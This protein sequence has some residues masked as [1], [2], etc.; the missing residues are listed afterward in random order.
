MAKN[1]KSLVRKALNREMN[2]DE[3]HAY[4]AKKVL[5]NLE[6]ERGV[7]SKKL[8]REC[9]DYA[10]DILGDK[11]YA[12]W[13]YVYSAVAGEF[14]LG[15]IPDNFYGAVVVPKL[16]GHYG[17]CSGL[18]PLNGVFFQAKEF[19][20][21]GSFINGL[22]LDTAY[23]V[24][25]PE[26]FKKLLF[27][28]C[29]R[30]VFKV[31]NSLKGIGIHFFDKNNFTGEQFER[32]G[33]GVFQR[34]VQQHEAFD[35]YTP[36]SVATI[37]ITTV[38]DNNGAASVRACYLRLG[39]ELD[40]HVQSATAVKIPI[41]LATGLLSDTGYE[42]SWTTIHSHPT[43][44]KGFAN[45]EIPNFKKCL[46]V[47]TSLHLKVPYVRCIGWDLIVDT[48]GEVIV[49]EWNG[50]HNGIKFT[51]ATQGPSFADLGWEKLR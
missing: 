28:D 7:L 40:T 8:I 45:I 18:K 42:P 33:N 4:E 24:H 12:H 11:K 10:A 9:D 2:F 46:D 1:V 26:N 48:Q 23:K 50:D 13:L 35:E 43:S 51:E 29:E 37:R 38:T 30:I 49:L 21:L 22:F 6:H 25:S 27:A 5:K 3:A 15:W 39:T 16:K 32:L 17:N 20:D 47:V 36:N 14:K 44:H 34:Y 31:D 41:H 19:P